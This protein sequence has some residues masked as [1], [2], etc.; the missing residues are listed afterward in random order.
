MTVGG[1]GYIFDL[2]LTKKIDVYCSFVQNADTND[3]KDFSGCG[4]LV[5]P[6][7]STSIY[8]QY[9]PLNQANYSTCEKYLSPFTVTKYFDTYGNTPDST[10]Q[11]SISSANFD[12]FLQLSQQMNINKNVPVV[13]ID[14]SILIK[15]Q[16]LTNPRPFI[17]SI[18]AD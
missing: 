6:H 16:E 11:F 9:N 8:Y 7:S 1:V 12:M 17:P 13:A 15:S 3:R 18:T 5:P 10:D 2:N 4:D 14:M